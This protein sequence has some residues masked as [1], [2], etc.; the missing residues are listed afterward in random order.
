MFGN[1]T[2]IIG[3]HFD[4]VELGAVGLLPN[5]PSKERKFTSLR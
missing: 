5:S 2:L 1:K 3:A 4:D